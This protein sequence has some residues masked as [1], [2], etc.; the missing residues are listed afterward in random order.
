[1]GNL[2]E[3]DSLRES[4]WRF[5][6]QALSKSSY[7][8]VVSSQNSVDASLFFRLDKYKFVLSYKIIKSSEYSV[9]E[10]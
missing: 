3:K 10:V 4:Q 2:K 8:L 5:P 7:N 1:M 6:D 9:H